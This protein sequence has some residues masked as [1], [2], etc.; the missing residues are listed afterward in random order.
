MAAAIN[1]ADKALKGKNSAEVIE[2]QNDAGINLAKSHQAKRNP[3]TVMKNY[4]QRKLDRKFKTAFTIQ[5][6][7]DLKHIRSLAIVTKIKLKT[8]AVSQR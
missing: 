8:T 4:N 7:Q 2:S 5:I 1:K 6:E 3:V